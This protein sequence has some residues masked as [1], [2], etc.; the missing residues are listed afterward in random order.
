MENAIGFYACFYTQGLPF[1]ICHMVN[2]FHQKKKIQL[3]QIFYGFVCMFIGCVLFFDVVVF[4]FVLSRFLKI[5]FF[6]CFCYSL[7]GDLFKV[8]P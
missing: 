8:Q 3:K 5:W 2:L 7:L 6:Y 1:L 4:F